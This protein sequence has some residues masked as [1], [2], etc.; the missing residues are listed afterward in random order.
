MPANDKEMVEKSETLYMVV[1]H[2]LLQVCNEY[3]LQCSEQ[4]NELSTLGGPINLKNFGLFRSFV[5]SLV[6]K[7]RYKVFDCRKQAMLGAFKAV[8]ASVLP[9]FYGDLDLTVMFSKRKYKTQLKS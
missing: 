4:V 3:E 9:D 2:T 8:T 7:T 1:D 6:D 5:Q